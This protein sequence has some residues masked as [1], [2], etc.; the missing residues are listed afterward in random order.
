MNCVTTG[1]FQ[2]IGEGRAGT[3]ALT[4]QAVLS[5]DPITEPA[6]IVFNDQTPPITS[7]WSRP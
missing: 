7:L 6:V 2:E 1:E 4:G 3:A 5:K